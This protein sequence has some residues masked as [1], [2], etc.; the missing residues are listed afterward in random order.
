[1]AHSL[2]RYGRPV[3]VFV[4]GSMRRPAG[5]D[6]G[7]AAF[8]AACRTIGASLA[9]AGHDLALCSPF[10]D[11]ADF[12]VLSG[13][14]T[15][16]GPT[17]GRIHFYFPDEPGVRAQL[18]EA[19]VASDVRR[20]QP[21]PRERTDAAWRNAW[22]LSQLAALDDSDVVVAVGGSETGSSGLLLALA[23]SRRMPILPFGF[24]DG[25]ARTV[26]EASFYE[27]KDTI[28]D[29]GIASLS[30]VDGARSCAELI[31]TLVARRQAGSPPISREPLFFISYARDRPEE[32]DFVETVLRRR[33]HVVHRD[34]S[35][36]GAGHD[37]HGAI[38][39][40]VHRADVFIALWCREYAC[41]P[42]CFD[43]LD[44]ALNRRERP[45][46]WIFCVDDTRI[47]PPRARNL[48][49]YR[50]S[51]RDAL[52]GHLVTLLDA[53]RSEQ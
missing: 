53:L 29:S 48:V 43:E 16:A 5:G 31:G 9:A 42:W 45:R 35:T 34:D 50:A 1:M 10:G 6:G 27:L 37:V 26:L 46:M 8:S 30:S 18:D 33:G 44:Q 13:A 49:H 22:L 20:P 47:V 17:A 21:P 52:Q 36:F 51:T 2:S 19:A 4:I 28:G 38:S 14:R 15:S 25:A 7:Q 11:S 32:G 24:V 40:S 39:E 3:R 12:H 23:R 41:S